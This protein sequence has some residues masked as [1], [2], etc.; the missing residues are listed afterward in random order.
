MPVGNGER[1]HP[2][3]DNARHAVIGEAIGADP[4][5]LVDRPEERFTWRQVGAR[6]PRL[7]RLARD[8]HFRA[9]HN[10]LDGGGLR[11]FR[12]HERHDEAAL[13][14]VQIARAGPRRLPIEADQF[15]PAQ[16]RR[17]TEREQRRAPGIGVE[18]RLE[19]GEEAAQLVGGDRLRPPLDVRLRLL[20]P[21]RSWDVRMLAVEG[22]A[23]PVMG[24]LDRA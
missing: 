7:D 8:R 13:L 14:D 22:V 15:G 4:L 5:A 18:L 16:R 17:P 2:R 9:R 21:A 20:S 10:H 1:A 23:G 3:L 11:C 19:I 24:E 12:A 6:H